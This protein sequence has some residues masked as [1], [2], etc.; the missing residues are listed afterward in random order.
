MKR[1][2]YLFILSLLIMVSHVQEIKVSSGSIKSFPAFKS[3]FVD[4]RNIDV[5]LPEG[6]SP[7]KKYAVLYMHDGQMLF[8]ST[9][10]WNH[11]EWKVDETAGKLIQENKI[12]NCIIVGIWNNGKYRHSEYFPQK[13]FITIPDNARNRLL[14]KQVSKKPQADNYLKFIVKELKPFI[15]SAFSTYKDVKNTFIMGSSMGGLISIYALCEYPKVFGGAACLSIHS[16]MAMPENQDE[17]NDTEVASKL[18]DYLKLNLPNANTR[19]IY[20]DYGD[21]TLDSIYKPYQEKID[22]V[23]KEKGYNSKWWITKYFPGEN[24]SEKAWAKRLDIPLI[25]LLKP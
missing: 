8:D 1:T 13:V 14:E 10:N 20:F 19:K 12:R 3:A 11:L 4:A 2:F 9:Y 5:W 6:Y 23:M 24:H 15:D 16:P 21:K 17:N 22:R 7:S 25:F 18:R